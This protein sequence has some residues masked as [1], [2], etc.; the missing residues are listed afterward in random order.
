M[1]KFKFELIAN[2]QDGTP[3]QFDGDFIIGTATNK[4][5]EDGSKEPLEDGTYTMEDGTSFSVVSGVIDAITEAI[6]EPAVEA[7]D[8]VPVVDA[9]EETAETVEETTEATDLS[10]LEQRITDLQNA[11]DRISETVADMQKMQESMNNQTNEKF[12]SISV[13][14]VQQQKETEIKKTHTEILFEK[15]KRMKY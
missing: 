2:L 15:I 11:I 12:A 5:K 1:K 9:P 7:A 10:V 3:I 6:S 8:A 4:I 14:S 13:V